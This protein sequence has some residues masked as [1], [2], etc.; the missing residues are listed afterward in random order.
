M[1][2]ARF[3]DVELQSPESGDDQREIPGCGIAHLRFVLTR[4]P[5]E[6]ASGCRM[7]DITCPVPALKA[8][9][10]DSDSFCSPR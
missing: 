2:S 5:P 10:C 9:S 8:R 7:V 3:P 1:I 4:A 6:W